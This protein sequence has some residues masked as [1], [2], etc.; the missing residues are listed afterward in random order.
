MTDL[1][2]SKALV[3]NLAQISAAAPPQVEIIPIC[4]QIHTQQNQQILERD[5]QWV[6]TINTLAFLL[7]F[8]LV[9]RDWRISAVFMLPVASIALTIGLCALGYPSLSMMVI[10]V[11]MAMAGSAVDY[12]IYVYTAVSMGSDP[13][14]DIRRIRR[15]LII[16]HLTTLGVFLAFLFSDIPAYRQLGWLTS[17]SLVLSLLAAIF[18]LPKLIRPGENQT[19]GRG[20]PLHRW[21]RLMIPPAIAVAA[22]L[23]VAVF[24]ARRTGFQ[25]DI[26]QMDGASPTVKQA[27]KDFQKTW[28]RTE[29]ELAILVVSAPSRDQAEEANGR[30]NAIMSSHFPEG[31][32]VSLSSFWPSAATR[33]ANLARWQAFWTPQRIATLRQNLATEGEPYG[34]T[35]DAF[36]PFFQSL[37][38]PPADQQSSQVISG[39]EDQFVARSNTDWQMLSFFPD[40]DANVRDASDLLRG[41]PE[42]QIVSR[43]AVGHAFADAAAAE[44]HFL[45]IISVIFI[46]VALLLLTRS[47]LKS[48]LIMLPA[49]VGLVALMATMVM[50]SLSMNIVGVVAV[51]LVLALASDYGVFAVYA[52]DNNETL[53]GQGMSSVHLCALTTMVG[54]GA[55]MLARHPALFLVGVTLTSGLLAGYLTAFLVIPAICYLRDRLKSPGVL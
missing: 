2:S 19:H 12:G 34:F 38:H 29:T 43:R 44:S 52:W 10:G 51:I 30:I 36:D 3:A 7:L 47:P 53:L 5:T 35:A 27:E 13:K 26:S 50:L 25:Q 41:H 24:L 54:T 15:P 33:K 14:S 45:V 8:I 55:L 21:G 48:L 20:M 32:F 1:A 28:G 18:L 22:L 42:V 31:Q 6:G 17:I 9:S 11:A 40:T 46:I 49:L 4:G 23:L 16:S 37:A 39:L